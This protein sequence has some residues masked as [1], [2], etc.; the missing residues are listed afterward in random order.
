MPQPKYRGVGIPTLIRFGCGHFGI[1]GAGRNTGTKISLLRRFIEQ[2]ACTIALAA[3]KACYG[4]KSPWPP[5]GIVKKYLG[6]FL[7]QNGYFDGR[8]SNFPAAIVPSH[9]ISVKKIPGR[10]LALAVV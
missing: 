5:G 7:A 6:G 2:T 8:S 1:N 9:K 4:I 3:P 10:L